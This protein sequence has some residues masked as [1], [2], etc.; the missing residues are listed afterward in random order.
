MLMDAAPEL[1]MGSDPWKAVNGAIQTLGKHV[2]PSDEVP[3]V[4]KT[5][6]RGIEQSA[7]KDAALQSL[8]RSMQGAG[9]GAAPGGGA[10]PPGGAP[11]AAPPP[12]AAGGGM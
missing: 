3:G 6:L 12:A 9:G 11:G 8:M 5:A 4:Q 7:G 10:P 2:S 1:P